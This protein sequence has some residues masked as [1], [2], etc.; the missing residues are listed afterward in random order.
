[1]NTD[2][3]KK[4]CALCKVTLTENNASKEHLI[5]R[6]IGGRK[7]VKE[8]ICNNC[9]NGA[10]ATWDAELAKS[11]NPLSL[12]CKIKREGNDVPAQ[13]FSFISGEKILLR[14][15]G[16]M[17]PSAP[18][19]SKKETEDG[20]LEI[21]IQA[22]SI[23]EAE[24]MLKGL[25]KKHPAFNVEEAKGKLSNTEIYADS[26]LHIQFQF[27]GTEAGRSLVKTALAW[28][29]ENG[30]EANICNEAIAYLTDQKAPACFGYYYEK[31][32]IKGRPTD[33]VLHCVA[34]SN[35]N[36]DGQL[37]AY[38]EYFSAQRMV[39]RLSDCYSGN[40]IH[41]IYAI[42][43][44]KGESVS[45][46]FNLSLSKQDIRE[47]YD[48][49]KIPKG[50]QESAMSI[51]LSI[52]RNN[53]FDSEMNNHLTQAVDYAFKNCGVPEGGF[54]EEKDVGKITHLLMEKLSPFLRRHMP[55]RK[56]QTIT[57]DVGRNDLCP[58]G[59]GKKYKKCCLQ[60]N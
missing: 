6:S 13:E 57:H 17:T 34:I 44:I 36:T 39:V 31:D 29:I 18:V 4:N 37:L 11:L 28:A 50:S 7:K 2:I 49:K 26:P 16:S 48:Y 15:D 60:S 35:R 42:D 45:L 41:A 5:P 10:G 47:V 40:D 27:G 19:F 8:F 54:I 32:L 51:P 58:C 23:A 3:Q 43:P 56:L 25:K 14:P 38:V 9:N 52:A 24:K 22:R 53:D 20:K 55:N 12:L 33:R 1:M 59:S 46:N 30:V 21:N